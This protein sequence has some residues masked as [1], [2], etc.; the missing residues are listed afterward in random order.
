MAEDSTPSG[1]LER[2]VEAGKA[3]IPPLTLLSALLFYFGY[4]SARSQYEY[5]GVDVDTIGLGTQDYIMRSPEPLLTPLLVYAAAGAGSV[6]VHAAVRRRIHPEAAARTVRRMRRLGRGGQVA[7]LAALISGL[8][9]LLGYPFLRDWRPYGLMTP[10]LI[11]AGSTLSGSGAAVGRLLRSPAPATPLRRTSTAFVYLVV[12]VSAF[13]MT[14]T[15][16]QWSGRGLAMDQANRLDKL[17]SVILDTKESLF[18]RSPGVQETK[19]PA[20]EGQTFHYRYR[21][22]R[23]LIHGKDRM[24]LVVDKWSASDS[25][26]IVP[27]DDSVRVQFQFQNQPP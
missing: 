27:L 12:A 15:V 2:L 11:A 1:R 9:L 21:H 14:A 25:T 18:L 13:W 20:S 22:L 23:L 24:F 17:P 10:L 4:V 6:A 3:V 19:L 5:F 26:I 8:L 7:G 16:A